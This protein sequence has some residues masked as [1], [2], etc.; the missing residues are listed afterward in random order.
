MLASGIDSAWFKKK[1]GQAKQSM[2]GLAKYMDLDVAA[3]SRTFSGNRK[4]QLSEAT[5]IAH[6]LRVPLGEVL[7][8]AGVGNVENGER[9]ILISA[10]VNESGQ[11]QKL[12]KA[13]PMPQSVIAALR[14]YDGLNIVAAQIRA[15]SGTL[16]IFNDA[17]ILFCATD[18]VEATAIGTLA[19]CR[20]DDGKQILGKFER[21]RETG[22]ARVR[23]AGGEVRELMLDAATPVLAIIP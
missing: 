1:L 9:P 17:V 3:V 8:H 14:A 10:A 16:A 22:E 18:I 23:L 2:R 7:R 19:I 12:K 15:A 5:K 6:F 13:M 21:V 4:L 20:S 11:V